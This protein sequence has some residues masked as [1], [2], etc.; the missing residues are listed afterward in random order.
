MERA[1]TRDHEPSSQ[2]PVT[3]KQ[4]PVTNNQSPDFGRRTSD[5]QIV[6]RKIEGHEGAERT[7]RGA[8]LPAPR[9]EDGRVTLRRDRWS[10][11]HDNRHSTTDILVLGEGRSDGTIAVDGNRLLSSPCRALPSLRGSAFGRGRLS[12]AGCRM[13]AI[14]RPFLSGKSPPRP[15]SWSRVNAPSV[16]VTN[17]RLPGTGGTPVPLSRSRRQLPHYQTTALPHSLNWLLATGH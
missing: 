13:S 12:V 7:R 11:P 8:S 6:E 5:F 17:D 4:Q 15:D 9:P 14:G 16:S 2:Q 10:G 3:S 1:L